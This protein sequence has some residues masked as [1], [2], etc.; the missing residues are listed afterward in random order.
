MINGSAQVSWRANNT[1]FD[2]TVVRDRKPRTQI[3]RRRAGDGAH[4]SRYR[5][6]LR[7]QRRA[8]A[9]TA[10]LSESPSSSRCL[11]FS[12]TVFQGVIRMVV[13]WQ[14]LKTQR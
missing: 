9:C 14:T 11:A 13:R 3:Q 5:G 4:A 1:A 8:D 2:R 6:V 10:T 7:P 12:Y